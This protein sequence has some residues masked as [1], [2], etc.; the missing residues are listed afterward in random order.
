MMEHVGCCPRRAG[1]AGHQ[2]CPRACSNT[3]FQHTKP[4]LTADWRHAQLKCC[5]ALHRQ[6]VYD[7]SRRVDLGA[8]PAALAAPTITSAPATVAMLISSTPSPSVWHAGPCTRRE[9]ASSKRLF[10]KLKTISTM[11]V[12]Q[13]DCFLECAAFFY[14][15]RS[16]CFASIE[17]ENTAD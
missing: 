7:A 8:A 17:R 3:D 4:Y 1:A 11:I 15:N 13:A 5:G 12:Q 9:C 14:S 10:N 6:N 2:V 16:I